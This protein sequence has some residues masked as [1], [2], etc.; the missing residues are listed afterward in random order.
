MQLRFPTINEDTSLMHHIDTQSVK[1]IF[2]MG[3]HRSGTTFLYD[4]IASSF[5]LANLDLY[6]LFFYERLIKNYLNDTADTDRQWLNDYIDHLG[7]KNRGLDNIAINDKT[8]EE[9]CWLLSKRN[10]LF[11][12]FYLNRGNKKLFVEA[13]KKIAFINPNTQATLLKNPWDYTNSKRIQKYFPQSRF[14]FLNRNP[15]N[16][17]NSTM[18]ANLKMLR[19]IEPGNEHPFFELMATTVPSFSFT[20]AKRFGS[21]MYK[22]SDEEFLTKNA[23]IT[24]NVLKFQLNQVRKALGELHPSSYM[25]VHYDDLVENPQ[26]QL[27]AVSDFLELDFIRSPELVKSNPRKQTLSPIAEQYHSELLPFALNT[28]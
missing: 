12:S 16:T 6:T 19:S 4:A 9:Y 21:K 27:H 10:K 20:M 26:K 7:I 15:I 22:M 24:K 14:I 1:P 17:L 3:A 5:P 8:V 25:I 18:N 28:L 23:K 11:P 13:C 2:I